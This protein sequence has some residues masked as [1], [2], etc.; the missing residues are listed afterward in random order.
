MGCSGCLCLT[1]QVEVRKQSPGVKDLFQGTLGADKTEL[2]V[3]GPGLGLS[4]WY[5]S[6][7]TQGA[8]SDVGETRAG[9]L[10]ACSLRGGNWA[11]VGEG[12]PAMLEVWTPGHRLQRRR[13]RALDS[14]CGA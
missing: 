4:Q 2:M 3:T 5:H 14:D 7:A 13:A 8:R 12:R 10:H 9:L 11:P 1:S 6:F